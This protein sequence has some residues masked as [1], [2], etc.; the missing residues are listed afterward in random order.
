MPGPLREKDGQ[1]VGPASV[2]ALKMR[3]YDV[4]AASGSV[5][6]QYSAII[7]GWFAMTWNQFVP[8]SDFC[9]TSVEPMPC[10]YS[11]TVLGSFW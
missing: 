1:L 5:S 2:R 9:A 3:G 8:S 10:E 6:A 7:L 11:A 4:D